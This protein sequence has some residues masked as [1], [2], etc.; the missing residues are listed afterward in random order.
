MQPLGRE[1]WRLAAVGSSPAYSTSEATA[2]WPEGWGSWK[3][4]RSTQEAHGSTMVLPDTQVIPIGSGPARRQLPMV[5]GPSSTTQEIAQV[6]P[7][8]SY[9]AHQTTPSSSRH[10]HSLPKCIYNHEPW[11]F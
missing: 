6:A 4:Q 11:F 2:P 9:K 5:K 3:S 1:H 8:C 10:A 7:S